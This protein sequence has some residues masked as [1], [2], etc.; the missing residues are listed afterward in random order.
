MF[1]KELN[2]H[3][4]GNGT[5]LTVVCVVVVGT[6]AR[7]RQRIGGGQKRTERL[8]SRTRIRRRLGK[9]RTGRWL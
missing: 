9:S 5:N 3:D 2:Y 1:P 7:D 8:V 4:C 6:G